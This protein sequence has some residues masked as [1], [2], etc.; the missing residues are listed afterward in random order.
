[1]ITENGILRLSYLP[2]DS[3]YSGNYL[4]YY[5]RKDDSVKLDDISLV[6][7]LGALDGGSSPNNITIISYEVIGDDL[8]VLTK[9]KDIL[10]YRIS[11][12]VAI[13][14][15]GNN[16]KSTRLTLVAQNN[17]NRQ[18]FSLSLQIVHQSSLLKWFL[19]LLF[20]VGTTLLLVVL[21]RVLRKRKAQE[22]L[23]MEAGLIP[24]G[25]ANEA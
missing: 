9:S 20:I 22:R 11:E 14:V 25:R 10:R 6:N 1:M 2:D 12:N 7:P 24:G 16:I 19:F 5:S 17:L 23:E 21:N 4:F 18:T 13:T 3:Q 8:V 15:S